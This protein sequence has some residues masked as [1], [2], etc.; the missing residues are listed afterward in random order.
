MRSRPVYF[1]CNDGDDD[2]DDDDDDDEFY[3]Y[4]LADY[5]ELMMSR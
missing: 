4:H 2:D 3:Q 5:V 1:Y